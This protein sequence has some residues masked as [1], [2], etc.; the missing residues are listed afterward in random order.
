MDIQAVTIQLTHCLVLT[1]DE[2]KGAE[3]I[4]ALG[5]TS[6][7]PGEI[8]NASAGVNF[9]WFSQSSSGVWKSGGEE[10]DHTYFPLYDL[11]APKTKSF[12]ERLIKRR[13]VVDLE[14]ENAF[15]PYQAPWGALDEDGDEVED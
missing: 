4:V 12:I 14:G 13:E 7:V 8:A 5:P 15:Y 3:A 6:A 1:D 11:R 2:A 10:G 9:K